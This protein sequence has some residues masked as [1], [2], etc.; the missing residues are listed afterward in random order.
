MSGEQCCDAFQ[1]VFTVAIATLIP[2]TAFAFGELL[3]CKSIDFRF[4]FTAINA[5]SADS[6][7]PKL[8]SGG[9]YGSKYRIN[10]RAGI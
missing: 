2:L 4:R 3:T 10:F 7:H 8:G 9:S 5:T 1:D 6:F